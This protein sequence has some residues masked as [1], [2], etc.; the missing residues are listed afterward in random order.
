[1]PRTYVQQLFSFFSSLPWLALAAVALVAAAG[2]GVCYPKEGEVVGIAISF[3][4]L[5][6]TKDLH[7]RLLLAAVS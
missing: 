3:A 7:L 1:M 2:Y 5:N 6:S 4:P